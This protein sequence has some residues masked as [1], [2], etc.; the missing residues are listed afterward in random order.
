MNLRE[1]LSRG[2]VEAEKRI[3]RVRERCVK[4]PPGGGNPIVLPHATS[5]CKSLVSPL[6][7][8]EF[9]FR[10][11][12]SRIAVRVVLHGQPAIGL[13][14][15]FF[16]C[17]DRNSQYL[18]RGLFGCHALTCPDGILGHDYPAALNARQNLLSGQDCDQGHIPRDFPSV[19]IASD[20]TISWGGL[21][22]ATSYG[23]I[24]G[25]CRLDS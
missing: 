20:P 1:I 11:R 24:T 7:S 8:L 15:L 10:L 23:A 22:V 12:V 3:D 13:P 19:P 17:P 9:V 6:N 14:D 16:R 21:H 5:S 18:I 25:C 4:S 2:H